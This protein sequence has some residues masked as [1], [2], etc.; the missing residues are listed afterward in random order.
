M[1]EDAER[2][3]VALPAVVGLVERADEDGLE[4][5]VVIVLVRGGALGDD[6][7]GAWGRGVSKGARSEGLGWVHGVGG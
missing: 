6:A 1:D 3:V 7:V 2:L 5:N 4:A